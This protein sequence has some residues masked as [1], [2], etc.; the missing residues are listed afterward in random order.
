MRQRTLGRRTAKAQNRVGPGT[1]PELKADQPRAV[2][3]AVPGTSSAYAERGIGGY[4]LDD[5]PYQPRWDT[6]TLG[7][8]DKDD[9]SQL[10][11]EQSESVLIRGLSHP[12]ARSPHLFE[13]P[14]ARKAGRRRI[15][16]ERLG[17]RRATGSATR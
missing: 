16:G 11:A 2:L 13:Q 17:R 3:K 15:R 5:W 4:Y 14:P 6:E 10:K 8:W 12:Q 9:L 7:Q 1:G